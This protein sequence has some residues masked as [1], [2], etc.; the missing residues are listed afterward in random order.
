[1]GSDLSDILNKDKKIEE[2]S[3]IPVHLKSGSG[4]NTLSIFK[5]IISVNQIVHE[6]QI[7]GMI[8]SEYPDL[9]KNDIKKV[10][11]IKGK[12]INIIV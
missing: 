9:I 7:I 2:V 6:N 3:I 4:K 10:I 8:K 12:I 5:P 11:Y 1:M